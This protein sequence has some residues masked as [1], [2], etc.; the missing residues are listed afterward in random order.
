MH[1]LTIYQIYKLTVYCTPYIT[2]VESGNQA[3][4]VLY[5]IQ[6]IRRILSY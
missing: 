3:H 2:T 6:L 4:I 5:R 1:V